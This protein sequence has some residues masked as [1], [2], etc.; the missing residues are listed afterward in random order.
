MRFA[1][2]ICLG[3]AS[4]TQ[5]SA[6]EFFAPS[7]RLSGIGV[8]RD[9][10]SDDLIEARTGLMVESQT[11]SIMREPQAL[12]GA[13]RITTNPKLQ[14]LFRSASE[15][16]GF[17][18]SVLEAIAYLESWGD[19]KAESPTGPKGVMQISQGT[20]REMGLRVLRNVRYR[21]VKERA[22]VRNKRN[23]VVYKTVRR[24][25]P[26]SV[27]VRDD[28]VFPERAIPAAARY[29]A[30]LE[31][32]FGG[33]DW[34]IFAYHCGEGCVGEMLD[35]T[36][37]ARG[38]PKDQVTVARMF[39]SAN[40]V[41]NRELYQA[42]Q[43]QMQ[44][45]YSPTYWFR[46]MRAQ[47]LLAL[48][49][50]DPDAF[51]SLVAEYKTQF[52]GANANRAPHRL[53]VWLKREDLLYHTNEDV[54]AGLG[55]RLVR[56]FDRPDYFGY[57]LRIRPDEP[58]N[59]DSLAQASPAALGTLMY[60]AFETR[61]LWEELKPKGEKFKP[62]EVTSL[63][64]PEDYA[65]KTSRSEALSHASGQVFDIDY[66]GLPP[67]EY[68]CLRFVLDDI[69]WDGYLGFVEEGRENLHIG[70]SPGSRGFFAS[71]FQEALE[72]GSTEEV[73]R[74]EGSG[75]RQNAHVGELQ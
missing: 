61:R 15:R 8:A 56:A 68:E 75:V 11:F 10:L 26:Y 51:E 34:A 17:P 40:P 32:K 69:G 63:V 28:R 20:A 24:R 16:S 65:V 1:L 54:R 58:E 48:Y 59:L 66:A 62:L 64:E 25:V 12:A 46:V 27:S 31:Q 60:I 33:R 52:P 42:I 14:E 5:A 22:Q 2:L 13:K 37:H 23:K 47:Q 70:C 9:D 67:G 50:S 73:E 53:S 45:D 7:H 35:L 57:T 19:P 43:N 36:R 38:I 6:P 41:W 4:L 18:A 71:V 44:R 55:S 30:G 29:L 49:R 3:L 21:T 72:K 39:F 74:G